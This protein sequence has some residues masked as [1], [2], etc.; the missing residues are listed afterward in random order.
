MVD[1]SSMHLGKAAPRHDPR[2]LQFASYL[3]PRDLPAP[4]PSVDY[5]KAVKGP[6]GMMGND[7]I[8]DCT[9]AAAGHLIME[10]TAD[11]GAQADPTTQQVIEAYSAVT[12]YDPTTGANDNGAMETDVLNYW[13]K[14]GVAG[15]RILAYAAL[16][17][18]STTHVENAID[19]FGGVYIGLALPKSAQTQTVW[20]VPPGG[21]TGDGRPGSWGGHAVPV[22]AYDS[23]GLTVITWGD[24]KTM[25][26][27]FW[28]TYCDEA[29]AV[30]SMDF[31]KANPND[32]KDP[33]APSG[34]DLT[35]LLDDL[36]A[37]VG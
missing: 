23:H 3:S 24:T 20:S 19:L 11:T 35:A 10:W 34:F 37:V 16:E 29:Y 21:P 15:H 17:P 1:H 13:R 14:T 36:K 12:G 18:R 25:T 8:G 7:T 32:P 26:W 6:W 5:T 33:V 22:L 28:E 9:C 2:T 27:Q 30:L 31:L 4:P